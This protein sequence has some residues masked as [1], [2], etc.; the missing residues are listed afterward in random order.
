MVLCRTVYMEIA[1][2]LV[3]SV[4]VFDCISCK[5]ID[6]IPIAVGKIATTIEIIIRAIRVGRP[7]IFPIFR[8]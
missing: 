8:V 5:T 4:V 7:K 1:V 3:V 2:V 6:Y